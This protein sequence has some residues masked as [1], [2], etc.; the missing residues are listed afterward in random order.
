MLKT[1]YK[2]ISYLEQVRLGIPF[3]KPAAVQQWQGLIAGT[4]FL[5]PSAV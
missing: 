2:P 3:D 5:F 4:F 1:I